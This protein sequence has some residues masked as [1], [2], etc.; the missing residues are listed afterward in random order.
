MFGGGIGVSVVE[1]VEYAWQ[2]DGVRT[3]VHRGVQRGVHRDV[4]VCFLAVMRLDTVA[5]EHAC[6]KG[7]L[8]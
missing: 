8:P 6:E 7:V 5:I 2:R 1:G 3:D 4:A